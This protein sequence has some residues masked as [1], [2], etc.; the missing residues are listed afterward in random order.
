MKHSL[1]EFGQRN[2]SPKAV[3]PPDQIFRLLVESVN[4]YAI[5]LLDCEGRI[6]SWNS[7]AERS[8]GY[9]ADEI[10]GRHFSCLY[11]EEDIQRNQPEQELRTARQFGRSEDEGWRIRKDGSRF[12]ANVTITAIYDP[13]GTLIGYAKITKN[14]TRRKETEDHIRILN[15]QLE[16]R[17]AELSSVNKE[18]ESFSYSV[19]HDLRAPLRAIDGFSLALLQDCQ[20]QLTPEG[21]SYLSGIRA[22]T[23]RMGRL[24]DDLLSLARTS[25][26]EMVREELDLSHMADDIVAQLRASDP[27]RKITCNIAPGLKARGDRLLVQVVLEN[28]LGN[29][30]KFTSKRQHGVVELSMDAGTAKDQVFYIRD[31]GAGF[32]MKYADRLFG[33]FQRMHAEHDFPGTGVGLA[34]V[35]R[36]I[37]RHGGSIWA[38]SAVD[39]GATFYFTVN[40]GHAAEQSSGIRRVTDGK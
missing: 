13:P 29:A 28:L 38:E 33:V 37:H 34:T 35:Q 20:D 18:L 24:I 16:L 40:N 27:N 23:L 30:W 1:R 11:P 2:R 17:Y 21:R 31:N 6:S 9:R 36:I 22:A 19:S 15:E 12:W 8:K 7:G 5:F 39:H 26:C 32:D 25:R 3:N 4:E 10:I 14:L